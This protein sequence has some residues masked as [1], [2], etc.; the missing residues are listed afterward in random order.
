MLAACRV[1]AV[2]PSIDPAITAV[3]ARAYTVPTD[4]PEADGSLGWTSTTL[5]LVE[6]DAGGMT[7]TGYTYADKAVALLANGALAD[8][9]LGREP[10]STAALWLQMQQRVRNLGRD[11]LAA[12]AISAVDCALWDLKARLLDMPLARLLGPARNRVPIY[13]S[14]GFTNYDEARLRGQLEG[15]VQRDGCRWVKMKVGSAPAEDPRRVRQAR[16]AIGAHAGLF[17][18][19]NG[20]LDR[21][22]ALRCA[23][24]FAGEGVSWFEEP[25]S[26]DD[27]AGLR[28]L[29]GR[30]PS[31]M[32]IAAGEYVYTLDGARQLLEADAVD[33]LQADVSRCGGITGFLRIAALAEAF[34][35]PLSGHCAPALHLHVATAAPGLRH[36]EWFHDHVRIEALLFDGA[37]QPR[38]GVIAADFTRPGCGLAFRQRDAERYAAAA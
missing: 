35:V 29:R 10:W 21:R 16:D 4:S 26:A 20:A 2:R 32:E 7:G 37:P 3:R 5:V 36:L 1:F 8:A 14:G 25:V 15:W 38:D 24:A 17:V 12:A 22:Q 23:E 27:L 33:V 11:G 28:L 6:I 13:G 31:G 9:L 19:A 34:H 18:D 30:G